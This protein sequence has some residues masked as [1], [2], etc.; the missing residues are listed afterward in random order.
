MFFRNA[1][2][3]NIGDTKDFDEVDFS[4]TLATQEAREPWGLEA[5]FIGFARP[6][7]KSGAL[8]THTIGRF[9]MICVKTYS[10]VLPASVVRDIVNERVEEIEATESRKISRKDKAAIKELV[11]DELLPRAFTRSSLTYAYI[12]SA[13]NLLIVDTASAKRAEEVTG[14]LREVAGSLPAERLKVSVPGADVLTNMVRSGGTDATGSLSVLEDLELIDLAGDGGSV[15]LKNMDTS[16]HEVLDFI[17]AGMEVVSMALE[18]KERISFVMTD[19]FTIKRLK[20]N[21]DIKEQACDS[22]GDDAASRF[23]ADF[24][25]MTGEMG[26]VLDDLFITF[27][28][29]SAQ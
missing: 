14:L 6:L 2:V 15:K 22:A 16:S 1:T 23:D 4:A 8:F 21:D 13:R 27:H 9:T 10:K 20:F 28:V 17:E 5:S 18:W 19:D 3:F 25:I 24:A 26:D 12:D 11:T 29:E 7:G